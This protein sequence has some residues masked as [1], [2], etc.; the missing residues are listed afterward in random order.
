MTS[1]YKKIYIGIVF[2]KRHKTVCIFDNSLDIMKT[3]NYRP[4][5]TVSLENIAASQGRS[6]SQ[7]PDNVDCSS[8]HQRPPALQLDDLCEAVQGSPVLHSLSRSQHHPAPDGVEGIAEEAGGEA[9]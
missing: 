4:N 7:S 2:K 9:D 8:S 5:K 6:P 1:L 3:L